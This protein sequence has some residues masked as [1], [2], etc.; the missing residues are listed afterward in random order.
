MNPTGLS[1][2]WNRGAL[3]LLLGI[4]TNI[5]VTAATRFAYVGNQASGTI[6]EYS[7]NSGNGALTPIAACPTIGTPSPMG[8][9]VDPTGRFLYVA[10]QAAGASLII[11]YSINP[12]T[13]A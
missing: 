11:V 10:S 12:T 4:A 13:A 5:G 8:L 9:A 3:V 7:I 1:K 2:F 6:S